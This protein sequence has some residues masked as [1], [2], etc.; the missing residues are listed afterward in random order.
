MQVIV[1]IPDAL[2]GS[3]V[4][5]GQDPART[6]LEPAALQ[7]FLASRISKSQLRDLLGLRTMYELDG[8]L[9]D[10]QIEHGSYTAEDLEQD[11]RTADALKSS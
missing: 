7:A 3:L 9:K 1:E 10:H 11:V 6:L 2:A 4:P 5:A 8:F